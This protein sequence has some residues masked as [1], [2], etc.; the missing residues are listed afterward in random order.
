VYSGDLA[1]GM[2]IHIKEESHGDNQALLVLSPTDAIYTDKKE[3]EDW[4]KNG[5]IRYY[6]KIPKSY[7]NSCI[8]QFKHYAQK[9]GIYAGK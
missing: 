2:F 5:N 7:Y 3:L 9:K 6:K 1:G 4:L 8:E